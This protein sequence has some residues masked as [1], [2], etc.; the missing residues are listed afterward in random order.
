MPATPGSQITVGTTPTL[1]C[2]A[3]TRSQRAYIQIDNISS[4]TV[5]TGVTNPSVTTVTGRTLAA[6]DARIISNTANDSE[7]TGAVYAVVASGTAIVL[8]TEGN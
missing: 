1:L 4:V 8:V 6:G 2:P 5:F 7:A 3:R